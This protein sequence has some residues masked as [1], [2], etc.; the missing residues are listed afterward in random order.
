M[1]DIS[2][3][4]TLTA[5]CLNVQVSSRK[6]GVYIHYIHRVQHTTRAFPRLFIPWGVYIRLLSVLS[7]CFSGQPR[8][9]SATNTTPRH[10]ETSRPLRNQMRFCSRHASASV[11]VCRVSLIYIPRKACSEKATGAPVCGASDEQFH[12]A[13]SLV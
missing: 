1:R 8:D 2:T 11:R 7:C 5:A 4:S 3:R 9:C 10:Q 12:Q 6:E 13:S